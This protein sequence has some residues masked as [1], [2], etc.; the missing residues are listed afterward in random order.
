MK[1]YILCNFKE[2]PILSEAEKP[3]AAPG[4]WW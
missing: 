2:P 1:A 4:R 3:G